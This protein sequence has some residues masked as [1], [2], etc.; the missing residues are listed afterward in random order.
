MLEFRQPDVVTF[1]NNSLSLLLQHL[2]E[3]LLYM[4]EALDVKGFSL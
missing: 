3:Y 1:W 4:Q 2:P